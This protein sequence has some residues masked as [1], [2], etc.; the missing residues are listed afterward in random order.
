MHSRDLPDDLVFVQFDDS[1][2]RIKR[3][4]DHIGEVGCGPGTRT[5]C[6][7][8]LYPYAFELRDS[9]TGANYFCKPCRKVAKKRG[10]PVLDERGE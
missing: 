8:K 6:G 9:D 2:G 5:L 10:I 4:R 1:A 3:V 7:R